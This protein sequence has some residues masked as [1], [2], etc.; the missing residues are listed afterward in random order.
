MIKWDRFGLAF[1]SW[2]RVL[3]DS[4]VLLK[5]LNVAGREVDNSLEEYFNGFV[6]CF[7]KQDGKTLHDELELIEGMKFDRGYI[8]PYFINAAKG[9]FFGPVIGFYFILGVCCKSAQKRKLHRN[10]NN[11]VLACFGC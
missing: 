9:I 8:S 6:T 1:T 5:Y 10:S 7:L 2:A 4:S 11:G 3:F